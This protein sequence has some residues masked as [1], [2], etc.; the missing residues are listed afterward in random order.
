MITWKPVDPDNYE[1]FDD[2]ESIGM[3]RT[4]LNE[5]HGRSCYLRLEFERRD[6]DGT[7]LFASIYHQ[8]QRPLQ[9]MVPHPQQHT[10]D[11]LVRSGF[12]LRRRCFLMRVKREDLLAPIRG[13]TLL[14]YEKG[15]AEYDEAC[16][17]LYRQYARDHA[18]ISPLTADLETFCRKLPQRILCVKNSAGAIAQ[19][20]FPEENEIAYMGS[21]DLSGFPAFAE[22]VLERMFQRCEEVEFE[23]DNVD[24][25]A[26]VMRG[27]FNRGDGFSLDTYLYD[28]EFNKR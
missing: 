2:G 13:G 4:H 25:V 18:P 22:A 11:F 19:Y 3:L 23:A 7:E 28:P 9:T 8:R 14:E 20:V 24:E 15:S 26:M 27:L 5:Y 16:R 1:L 10:A 17:L 6:F 21:E 12:A